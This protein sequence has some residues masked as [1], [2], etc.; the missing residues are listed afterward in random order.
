MNVQEVEQIDAQY[1]FRVQEALVHLHDAQNL[2]YKSV[3]PW[4]AKVKA[5]K[6]RRMEMYALNVSL[7]TAQQW[8]RWNEMA[9][10]GKWGILPDPPTGFTLCVPLANVF[11]T[12]YGTWESALFTGDRGQAS[13]SATSGQ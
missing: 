13:G 7:T 2:D 4:R 1:R 11:I 10:P 3:A 12:S 5:W 8:F 6:Q 9:R